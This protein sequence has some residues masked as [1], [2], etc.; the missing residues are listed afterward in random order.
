MLGKR[1]RSFSVTFGE[2]TPRLLGE[3]F[4]TIVMCKTT[5]QRLIQYTTSR[6]TSL[7]VLLG[8]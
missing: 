1:K 4:S 5:G 3:D 6:S 8:R 2:K 7:N